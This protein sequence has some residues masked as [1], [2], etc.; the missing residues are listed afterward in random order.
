MSASIALVGVVRMA[1]VMPKHTSVW[2]LQGHQTRDAKVM[3]GRMKE[4]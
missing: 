4:A 1:P 3:N 2:S